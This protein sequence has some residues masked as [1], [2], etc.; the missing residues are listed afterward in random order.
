[1]GKTG[2]RG[3]LHTSDIARAA[4]DARSEL[5]SEIDVCGVLTAAGVPVTR[6]NE[7]CT[8]DRSSY[9]SYRCVE[10]ILALY[11]Q[12]GLNQR[13]RWYQWV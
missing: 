6:A 8:P 5:P 11:R 1:M 13:N 4:E 2:D 9:G 10:R 3:E 12:H 7:D